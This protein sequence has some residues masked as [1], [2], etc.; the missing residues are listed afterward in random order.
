MR[1][2]QL[3][4]IECLFLQLVIIRGPAVAAHPSDEV[5]RDF[6]RR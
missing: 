3:V 2:V 5:V 1:L 6:L 4:I